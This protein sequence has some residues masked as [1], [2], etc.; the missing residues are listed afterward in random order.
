MK[1][2]RTARMTHQKTAFNYSKQ[3]QVHV[4]TNTQQ[5]DSDQHVNE[6]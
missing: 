5:L 4:Y 3:T 2:R 6:Y 1:R